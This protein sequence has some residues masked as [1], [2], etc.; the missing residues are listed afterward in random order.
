MTEFRQNTLWSLKGPAAREWYGLVLADRREGIWK[1]PEV[2]I[3]PARAHLTLP[4]VTHHD[5]ICPADSSPIGQALVLAAWAVAPIPAHCLER[6]V[7]AIDEAL[8]GKAREAHGDLQGDAS[9]WTLRPFRP[10]AGEPA[11][12]NELRRSL[13]A[14][15]DGTVIIACGMNSERVTAS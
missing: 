15:W 14:Y 13:H 7:G 12:H 1:M 2:V 8:V 9:H 6:E 3:I 4:E 10:W 11:W 5:V